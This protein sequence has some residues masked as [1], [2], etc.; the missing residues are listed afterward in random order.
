MSA[1][2]HAQYGSTSDQVRATNLRVI[3]CFSDLPG[4]GVPSPL[5]QTPTSAHTEKKRREKKKPSSVAEPPIHEET[6]AP[7][8]SPH[9][10]SPVEKRKRRKSSTKDTRAKHALRRITQRNRLAVLKFMMRKRQQQKQERAPTPILPTEGSEP[11]AAQLD[12]T[13]E[14]KS[15]PIFP[16][17]IAPCL[18]ISIDAAQNIESISLYY[19]RRR[20]SEA[21]ARE[22]SPTPAGNADNKLGLLIEALEF[23]ETLHENSKHGTRPVN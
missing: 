8:S 10:K 20:K 17:I 18:K 23:M 11:V 5:A 21:M 14:N 6:L 9:N 19:H 12:A 1:N 2:G 13:C 22:S 16:E 4:N 7:K 15:E 3:P